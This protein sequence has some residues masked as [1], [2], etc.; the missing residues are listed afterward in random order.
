MKLEVKMRKLAPALVF[1]VLA[2]SLTLFAVATAQTSFVTI[3]D[4]HPKVLHPG[5]TYELTVVI[6]NNGDRD[7]RNVMLAFS[8][9]PTGTVSVVGVSTVNIIGL[10]GWSEKEI[11]LAVHVRDGAL[12]GTYVLPVNIT[13]EECYYVTGVGRICEPGHFSFATLSLRVE[14]TPTLNVASVVVKHG[15]YGSEVRPGYENVLVEVWIE[16]SG[17]A[18]AED[19][20]AELICGEGFEPSASQTT[21]AYIGKLLPGV[22]AQTTFRI[23]V[24]ED[25]TA[26]EHT[27]PLKLTYRVD[28]EWEEETKDIQIFVEPKPKFEI[29]DIKTEPAAVRAGDT[30]TLYVEVKNVGTENAKFVDVAAIRKAEQPFD[31]EDR[32]DYVGDLDVGKSGVACLSFEVLDDATSKIYFL[33]IRI[34]CSGDPEVGDDNVYTF[35]KSVPVEV[36]P[37]LP[38]TTRYLRVAFVVLAVA[39]VVAIAYV[40]VRRK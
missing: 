12:E 40:V 14:G 28:D 16:N 36:L 30:V 33:D 17:E 3:E 6:K 13:W 25:V 21:V 29:V 32:S 27:L 39:I 24:S 18:S 2:A 23:D 4:V 1:V 22:R 20:K 10:S 5:D 26:G 38:K 34:R 11:K 35:Y 19:V 8:P 7:A 37:G 9:D 15:E 31:F